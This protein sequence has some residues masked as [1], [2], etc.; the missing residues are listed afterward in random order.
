MA[1]IN[2]HKSTY[3]TP[4]ANKF[5][6][7]FGADSISLSLGILFLAQNKGITKNATLKICVFAI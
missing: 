2:P 5:A 6:T 7:I 1:C 3:I 4:I